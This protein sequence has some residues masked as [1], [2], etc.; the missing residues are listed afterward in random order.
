MLDLCQVFYKRLFFPC[1]LVQPIWCSVALP[2]AIS[3]WRYGTQLLHRRF[4]S[5][6]KLHLTFCRLTTMRRSS[7]TW[8]QTVSLVYLMDFFWDICNHSDSISQRTSVW[9]L[10]APREWVHPYA[11]FMF[12]E[13]KSMALASTLALL[14]TRYVWSFSLLIN[15]SVFRFSFFDLLKKHVLDA[16]GDRCALCLN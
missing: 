7:L 5:S 12:R 14:C 8:N 4:S 11:G 16:F 9:F 3:L 13:R 1:Q 2:F 10:Y 15:V 6:W